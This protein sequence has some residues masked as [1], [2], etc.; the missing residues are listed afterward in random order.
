MA[1]LLTVFSLALT[2]LNILCGLKTFE[3]TFYAQDYSASPPLQDCHFLE[4]VNLDFTRNFNNFACQHILYGL[5]CN[6][7]PIPTKSNRISKGY[8]NTCGWKKYLIITSL[9]LAGD[10]E[11]NPG[12][13]KS[14]C[15]TCG[16]TL[17]KNLKKFLKCE[18]CELTFHA[19]CVTEN[20][21]D[22]RRIKSSANTWQCFS[23]TLPMFSDSIFNDTGDDINMA[24]DFTLDCD[25][26][27]IRHSFGKGLKVGL[28]N[29]N[30]LLPK[31][32]QLNSTVKTLG[33]NVLCVNETWL[34]SEIDTSEIHFDG[35]N[36]IRLDRNAS[37][38]NKH[39][40]GGVAIYIEDHIPYRPRPDLHNDKMELCWIEINFPNS[41][42][43]LIGSL[44][45]PPDSGAAF[46]EELNSTL[47][48][49]TSENKEC[50]LLGDFNVNVSNTNALHN[51]LNDVMTE[52]QFV[53]I[54]KDPTR[55]TPFSETCIDLIF[56]SHTDKITKSGVIKTGLSDHYMPYFVRK[57]AL[58]KKPP[59]TIH[60]RNYKHYEADAFVQYMWNIPWSIIDIFNDP[61]D[62]LEIFITF[63]NDAANKFAPLMTKRVKGHD[64]PWICGEIRN[65]MSQRDI[66]KARAART[67]CPELHGQY[68]QLRN[69]VI[70][71]CRVAKQ[72]YYKNLIN[73]NLGNSSKMWKAL[74]KLLPSSKQST[75][76]L[77]VDG[78][79]HTEGKDI[80]STFNTFFSNIGATLASKFPPGI[81]SSNPYPGFNAN[82]NFVPIK[83]EFTKKELQKLRA[84]KATGLDGINTRLLKDASDVV[85]GP[86]TN[87]MNASLKTGIVPSM[88]KHA[89]VTP[90]Y[91]GDSPQHPSNYRPISVLPAC[92]KIFERAVQQQLLAYFK[93]NGILC[94][95]QSGFR[96]RHSTTT[97]TTHITD[98]LLQ[99]MDD[100]YLTGAIY[101][102]LKKA[103]DTVDTDTLLFKLKCIGIKGSEITWFNNYLNE[104]KQQVKFQSHLSSSLD[105]N[106][107]VPQGSI[108]GPLLFI[109]FVNDFK[110]CLVK[111][112]VHLYADDTIL[113]FKSTSA[114]EIKNNLEHDLLSASEWFYKNKLH[115]NI[116]K[117]KFMLFGTSKRLAKTQT[118]DV[119]I[120][121]EKLEHVN[122]YKYLGVWLD[123]TLNWKTHLHK[124]QSKIK[125]RLGMLRRV[126]HC[127]DASTTLLLY[128]SIIL[129]LLDYCDT[130]YGNC[131]IADIIKLQILQNRAGKI[132][133]EVPYDTR[134]QKVLTDLNWFYMT[135]RLFYHRCILMFKCLNGLA[136]AYLS[137]VFSFNSHAYNTRSATRRNLRLPKC[138]SMTGQK[139]FHYLGAKL[140]N[141]LSI[142]TRNCTTIGAFKSKLKS[143][144]LFHRLFL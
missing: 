129:P 44:Y 138:K 75:T 18:V 116:S 2:V 95:E 123:S 73:E 69:T 115:L 85:A 56:A 51:K 27:Q 89:K 106:C 142:D 81:L 74:K 11:L 110:N 137:D 25:I 47:N 91:K 86:I 54:I 12:P 9:L 134:T 33:L 141:T 93:T 88:W 128:N 71:K 23:C 7:Q 61:Q 104:R 35:Y 60:V 102:D 57:T 31:L 67:K 136:P 24:H 120:G 133:L 64:N 121:N 26:E 99:N 5:C 109:F 10:V 4:G 131:N 94:D 100:G 32:D 39:S 37:N 78:V 53:Q 132:I 98:Y 58:P 36:V 14:T 52:Q 143:E 49:V 55:V 28:L 117:C 103:F 17:R 65:L 50:Y 21:Y 1:A 42:P 45:R 68:K 122:H 79:T 108:L 84:S 34:N 87:I 30:R 8:K 82:F 113:L 90:I 13:Q 3:T 118:P 135:E 140:W 114:T 70:S 29:I 107:G 139:A 111:C 125:Q 105:I 41:S 97:A 16:L 127:I 66:M 101:L 62:M 48:R 96:E 144:I 19:R 20:D 83:I 46:F 6:K 77:E 15:G 80:A 59:R 112:K 76:T 126:R 92:M 40:G 63:F 130:V 119:Y 22:F 43:V 72:N 38:S 124:M